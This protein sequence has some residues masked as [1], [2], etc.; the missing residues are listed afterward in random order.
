[1]ELDDLPGDEQPETEAAAAA[2]LVCFTVLAHCLTFIFGNSEGFAQLYT[3]ILVTLTLY[4]RNVFTGVVQIALF[5]V[6]PAGFMAYLPAE[7]VHNLDLKAAAAV[8]AFAAVTVLATDAIF[9]WC[10]R[11]YE[12]GNLLAARG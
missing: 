3:Q 4:P 2:I 10:L 7:V 6:L 1:M 8:L 5:T 11:R 9:R 12:S